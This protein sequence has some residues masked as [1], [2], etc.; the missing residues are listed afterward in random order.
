MHEVRVRGRSRECRPYGTR[1]QVCA[2]LPTTSWWATICRPC[3]TESRLYFASEPAQY[4]FLFLALLFFFPSFLFSLFSLL[5]LCFFSFFCFPISFPV[6][7]PWLRRLRRL[8]CWRPGHGDYCCCRGLRK[9]DARREAWWR[10]R[11]ARCRGR[12]CRSWR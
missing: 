5:L 11:R 12:W 2:F 4:S 1:F 9:S 8:P 3:G 7:R 10:S 6:P